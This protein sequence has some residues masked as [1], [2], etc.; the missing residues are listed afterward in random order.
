MRILAFCLLTILLIYSSLF[1]VDFKINGIYTA[2]DQS[3]HA[4]NF[5]SKAYVEEYVV[6]VL[7]FQIRLSV[8][9]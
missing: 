2:W 1:A 5:D 7:R 4:F 8:N 9:G 3:Q 6:Q